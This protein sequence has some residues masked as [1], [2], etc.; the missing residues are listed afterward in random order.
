MAKAKKTNAKVKKSVNDKTAS[1]SRASKGG[2]TLSRPL[3]FVGAFATVGL[4]LVVRSLA[5]TDGPT[6]TSTIQAEAHRPNE[7]L[8]R[9][10]ENVPKTTEDG[11]LKRFGATQKD[12][13]ANVKVKV[14]SVPDQALDAVQTALAKNPAVE[15]VEKNYQ[16]ELTETTPNDLYYT[17]QWSPKKTSLSTLW[18]FHRG[19]ATTIVAVIDT[20]VT[21]NHEDL[22][23]RVLPGYDF[24]NNDADPTDDN[25]HGTMVAGIVGGLTNNTIGT[26]ASCWEC[27]I[28]PVKVLAADNYGYYSNFA[29]GITYAAD[30]GAKVINLSLIGT[31]SSS[32]LDSAV[33]Y[34]ISKGS[35]VIAA[36]GNANT[37]NFGYPAASPG[38]ISVAASTES[39]T[40][41][42]YSNYGSWVSIAAPGTNTTTSGTASYTGFAG[43]SS[44]SPVVAGIAG[45]LLTAV[46]GITPTQLENAVIQNVD[47]VQ[48]TRLIGGGRVNAIKAYRALTG[49]S[50]PI[51]VDSLAPTVS[52]AAPVEGTTI[53]GAV[54]VTA[55]ATDNTAVS[56]V[57]FYRNGALVASDTTIPYSMYWDSLTTPNGGYTLS[58]RA[59][60]AAGNVGTS[61]NVQVA[62]NNPTVADTTPPTVVLATPSDGSNVSRQVTIQATASDNTAVS[63]M[64]I[65]ID[66]KLLISSA[67]GSIQT[68]WN[69]GAKN[70]AKGNHI[71]TVK[72]YDAARNV[73]ERQITVIK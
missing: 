41:A 11:L 9:F 3:L 45:V 72:A 73:A 66:G 14:I 24:V 17:N 60:D 22:I 55:T 28:L 49:T 58:A 18:D 39:D 27:K 65:Y 37:T 21:A 34:A 32:T 47:A 64:E 67:T 12:E 29:K 40:L 51:P 19:S 48:G 5:A 43:T 50:T 68:R 54:A 38:A 16:G 46:P 62:L 8:I 25:G 2:F 53:V 30:N 31:S 56:K 35:I 44:A 42:S 6:F 69:A 36:A 52:I 33:A 71:I 4:Y 23:S 13:I 15:F 7:L 26:A 61:A 70:V 57:D 59:T 1:A 10:R 63:A 20:G